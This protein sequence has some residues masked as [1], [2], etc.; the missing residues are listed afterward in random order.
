MSL[1]VHLFLSF[2]VVVQEWNWNVLQSVESDCGLGP[3]S[4]ESKSKSRVCFRWT[5][6]VTVIGR[7]RGERKWSCVDGVVVWRMTSPVG[8]Y[9]LGL[10]PHV[11]PSLP[12]S[13]GLKKDLEL[14]MGIS[15]MYTLWV[16]PSKTK[17]NG[18]WSCWVP[19]YSSIPFGDLVQSHCVNLTA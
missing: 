15:F 13:P 5:L 9:P 12:M 7:R 1:T 14:N 10:Y 6:Q 18:L 4:L 16:S 19:L 2:C 17:K 11:L 3:R 8:L